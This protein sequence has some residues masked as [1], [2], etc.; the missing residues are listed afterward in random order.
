MFQVLTIIF[1]VFFIVV[2]GFV[3]ARFERPNMHFINQMILDLLVPALVFSVMSSKDFEIAAYTG[4]AIAATLIILL[5]GIAAYVV[6]KIFSYEWRTLVPPMMFRNW[7]NLGIP[8][9]VFTFGEQALNA[10]VI[11]FLV[12]NVFHFTLGIFLMSGRFRFMDFFRTPVIVAMI[13]G[14]LVNAAD[15]QLP[16]ALI[17]PLDMIGQAAIPMMLLSLG[18][19]LQHVRWNDLSMALVGS[20]LG[21]VIGV[22][23][24]L[25]LANLLNLDTEQAKQIL[26]FGALPC[27]F[28]NLLNR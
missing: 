20:F 17:R 6:A 19:R 28:S 27:P 18:V 22:S 25:L 11:L 23:L 1:P 16:T 12:G 14:L 10:A 3:Y 8:L 4:L 7:G 24:A 26:I 15:W 21:P 2:C 5:S 9:I 13:L